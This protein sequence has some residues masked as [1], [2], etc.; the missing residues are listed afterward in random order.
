MVVQ[1]TDNSLLLRP[2]SVWPHHF[3]LRRTHPFDESDIRIATQFV[4]ALGEKLVASEQPFFGYLIDKCPQDVVA[5]SMQHRTMDDALLPAIIT[6][7]QKWASQ[8]YEGV[9]ISVS[10]GVDCA[11]DPSRISSVHLHDV[12]G[13]DYAKVLSNGMDTILVVSPSGHIVEHVALRVKSSTYARTS[14]ASFA[15]NRYLALAEWAKGARVALT[16]NRQGEILVFKGQRLQF[17]FRRGAWSHFPHQ[18]LIA[19]MGGPPEQRRL[20]RALYVSCLDI[21]FARTG[22]CIAVANGRSANKVSDYLSR[23]DLLASC[24][25]DKATLLNHLIGQPFQEIP[26]AI[27]EEMAALDGAVVLEGTGIVVAAGA[28][29]RVP[30]GS[31]GGGRRAAAKALS[32][33]GLA[34]KVS[35]DGAITAFTDRGTR[36]NP[37][38]AFDVCV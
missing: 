8:T 13:R 24:K 19:R 10:I 38:I 31:E 33:L 2:D 1:E 17:A 15:P 5:W 12:V 7:L 30:G 3:R 21:S 36:E 18:A 20:M 35:S 22:G 6:T 37:E 14:D 9:R 32:R 29:V 4:R 28:I 25:T 23:G 27:R 11:P 34:V 26:R 16:L